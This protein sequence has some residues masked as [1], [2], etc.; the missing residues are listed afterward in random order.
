LPGGNCKE[1]EMV[2]KGMTHNGNSNDL[3]LP[4]D[5]PWSKIEGHELEE[6]VYWLL[7]DMGAKELQW[8]KGSIGGTAAD[9]G[10]DLE[11][12]FQVPTP[13]GEVS[14]EKWWIQVK[15]RNK[16]VE[17]EA[18][19]NTL[20][21]TTAI[22]GVQILIIVTNTDYSNPTRDW[23]SSWQHNHP[24]PKVRLWS[25]QDLE[26]IISRRPNVIARLFPNALSNQGKISV[27]SSRF[28]TQHYFSGS[29]VLE[30]IWIHRSSLKFTD[31]DILALLVSEMA[32]GDVGVRSWVSLLDDE[33][34]E[35]LLFVALANIPF[36]TLRAENFGVSQDPLLE[37]VAFIVEFAFAKLEFTRAFSVFNDPM[38]YAGRKQYPNEASLYIQGIIVNRMKW[39]LARA[40]SKDCIRVDWDHEV[41]DSRS[42]FWDR[43]KHIT[44]NKSQPAKAADL[45]I[46]QDTTKLCNAG[47]ILDKNV[48]CP[49]CEELDAENLSKDSIREFLNT[50]KTI[51]QYRI[52]MP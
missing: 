16:T 31:K 2:A 29:K 5:I 17:P 41:D 9:G 12:T 19:K 21:N 20:N 38:K 32:N 30:E 48:G 10:R 14:V 47:L 49:L 22:S 8:R 7:D 51:I 28:W 42:D 50:V 4:T 11:A 25:R 37:T 6:L 44:K 33:G 18:I 39:G 40:C 27:L 15:G 36:L 35:M 1:F 43:F 23:V 52:N 26:R 46:I 3:I 34:I 24:I 13:D 45:L